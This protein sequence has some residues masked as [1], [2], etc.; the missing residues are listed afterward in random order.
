MSNTLKYIGLIVL[1]IV[2]FAINDVI[3][4]SG[5]RGQSFGDATVS[6]FPT[7]YSNGINI[8][9]AGAKQNTVNA[10]YSQSFTQGSFSLGAYTAATSTTSTIVTLTNIGKGMNGFNAAVGDT[11]IGGLTTAPST[12]SFNINV[13]I[14][15]VSASLQVATASVTY[16]NGNSAANT[17]ATGT[18]AI[19][20]FNT[21]Y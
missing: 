21:P 13:N 3:I 8:G 9:E 20:C 10:V 17:I 15:A 16:W 19:T 6:L 2:L 7:W 12:S 14:T 4:I 18:L 11:C 5:V 1:V